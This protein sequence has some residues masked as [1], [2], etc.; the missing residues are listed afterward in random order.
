[1][2]KRVSMPKA[3]R[4]A[5]SNVRRGRSS[6]ENKVAEVEDLPVKMYVEI[7]GEGTPYIEMQNRNTGRTICSH[8]VYD[9]LGID[10]FNK[11]KRSI[12]EHYRVTLKALRKK[13]VY[14]AQA[15]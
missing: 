3:F 7:N 5:I 1:M 8:E 10:D 13:E 15:S 14:E 2:E 9:N 4:D 12:E 11:G 6:Y